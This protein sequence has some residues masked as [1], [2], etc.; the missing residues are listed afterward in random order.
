MTRRIALLAACLLGLCLSSHAA[1]INDRGEVSAFVDGLVLPLMEAN[2]SPSGAVAIAY[3]GELVFARG[4]GYEDM[5]ERRP[6][7]AER[8]LFRPGSVSK[9]FTWVAVMQ[10]VEQGRLDLDT[11]VNDYLEDFQIRDSWPEPVTLRHIMTH[12]AGFE[13]GFLGYLIIDDP[14][15]AVPLGEA[16]AR[17]QPERIN[18]PGAQSAYSNYATALAGH[19]VAV[20]SGLSFEDYID[21]HIFQPLGMTSSSFEEPLP[22]AL[23]ARMAHSYQFRNGGFVEKPFEIV[24]SFGPAGGASSTVTDMIRFAEAIRNGGELDG[25]RIL[26]RDTTEQMLSRE[27]SHDDRVMGMALGFYETDY[28]GF[29]VLG[30]GGDTQWFHSTFGIDRDNELSIFA[31]FGGSAGGALRNALTLS[32]YDEFFPRTEAPPQAPA[33]FAERAGR[34]TGAYGA[35]RSNFSK[36]EKAFGLGGGMTIAAGP[37]NSLVL[38]MG[39]DSKQ[40]VEVESNLFRERNALATIAGGMR[41]RL[42]AFQEDDNG[43]ITGFVLDGLPFMSTRRLGM[44]DTPGFNFTL[45]G[46]SMLIFVGVLARRFYQRREVRSWPATDRSA[47]RA[48]TVTSAVH[49][50]TLLSGV[51]LLSSIMEQMFVGIPLSFKLW[52]LLPILSVL[53]SVWLLVSGVRVWLA[54]N[55][56]GLMPRLRFTAVVAAGLFMAWFYWYWNILGYRYL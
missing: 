22:A 37:D 28:N 21:T 40:Y 2:S 54:G 34:Y 17:Y 8:T 7:D 42:L 52:L 9:L 12:T 14:S 29:R 1:D 11:D 49:L 45:L 25:V 23:D 26:E 36:I 43:E 50:F 20:V 16:M 44:Q 56:E 10:L 5:A 32:F 24:S 55:F 31:S 47:Q 15:R 27:F 30:H 48:A 18:P 35:W 39:E 19:I 38:T 33:D 46:L 41:P 53:C 13:E 3:R 4:Y 51:L 6:V